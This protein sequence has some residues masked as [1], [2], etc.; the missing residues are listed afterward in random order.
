MKI[1]FLIILILLISCDNR[2]ELLEENVEKQAPLVLETIEPPKE[3]SIFVGT[4]T[5]INLS[6]SINQFNNELRLINDQLEGRDPNFNIS[7]K[8]F[9]SKLNN[10]PNELKKINNSIEEMNNKYKELRKKIYDLRNIFKVG[11]ICFKIAAAY[12]VSAA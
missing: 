9:N 6:D 1:I 8:K 5:N 10:I 12:K 2:N 3:D 11:N 7:L 4:Q